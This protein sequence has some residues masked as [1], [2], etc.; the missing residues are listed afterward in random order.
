MD[1]VVVTQTRSQIGRQP[2]VRDT[3]KALG[4]G[5]IG[6]SK[7]LVLNPAVAGMIKRVA[8]IVSVKP[9]K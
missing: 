6:K 5:S 2:R 9:A 8:H 4:L 3:L 7:E 1:K